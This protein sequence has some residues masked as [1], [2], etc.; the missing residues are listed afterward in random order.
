MISIYGALAFHC[1]YEAEEGALALSGPLPG[2]EKKVPGASK[3]RS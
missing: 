3:G 2:A 1:H